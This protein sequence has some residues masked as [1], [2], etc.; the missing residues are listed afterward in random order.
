M[1]G[2]KLVSSVLQKQYARLEVHILAQPFILLTVIQRSGA[3]NSVSEPIRG[4]T[5]S[6]APHEVD[7]N[8][9]SVS[10]GAVQTR[11]TTGK[12]R[13]NSITLSDGTHV[14]LGIPGATEKSTTG[15]RY[16]DIPLQRAATPFE[17]AATVL[18]VVSPLMSYVDGQTIEVTGGKW[19]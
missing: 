10:F 7:T 8:N 18:A 12:D 3:L 1:H 11:L 13:G 2:P 6:T 19:I 9:N 17:A 5:L 15:N 4:F 14:A 16:A